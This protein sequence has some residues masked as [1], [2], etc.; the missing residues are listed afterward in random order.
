MGF[1]SFIKRHFG[2]TAKP[3]LGEPL[4]ENIPAQMSTYEYDSNLFSRLSDDIRNN[5]LPTIEEPTQEELRQCIQEREKFMQHLLD[6][7]DGRESNIMDA[8][9]KTIELVRANQAIPAEVEIWVKKIKKHYLA[10]LKPMLGLCHW[11]AGMT[12]TLYTYRGYDWHSSMELYP[13]VIFD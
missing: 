8:N 1:L 3:T 11:E 9:E 13:N 7:L 2:K 4:K 10:D 5:N 12:K 6:C